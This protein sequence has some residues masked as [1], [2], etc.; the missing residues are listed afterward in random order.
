[1]PLL[2]PTGVLR[3]MGLDA[4][5]QRLLLVM[6]ALVALLLCAYTIAKV[7]RDALF[8]SEYGALAL[9]YAYIGV[10]LASLVSV[11][12]ET[13]VAR[14]LSRAHATRFTQLVAIVC[15]I[16]AAL[17]FPMARHIT[18]GLFYLWTGSQAMM[19]LPHF[20]VIALDAWDSRR[21]RRV[22]PLLSGCGLLGGVAGGAI[23]AWLTP[24]V[25]RD[26]LLWTLS[27]LLVLAFFLTRVAE[28][29]AARRRPVPQTSPTGSPWKTFLGS[30]YIQFLA[31]GLAL[32]VAVGTLVD[33]QFKYF[34][35]RLYP[36]P[37]ALTQF[38]GT[39]YVGLNTLALLFQF[40]VAGWLL[41]RM[42]L[43]ASTGL[44]PTSVL[45]FASWLTISAGPWAVV[46]MRWVQG[47]VFQTL[48][49]SSSEIY[50]SALHPRDRRNV[51]PAIDTL[52]DRWADALVGVML[53]VVLRFMRVPMQEIALVTAILAGLWL[54]V[55]IGLNRSYARAFKEA[56]SARWLET[57]V[58]P[59][60]RQ[61]PEARRAI[62]E[63]I[64]SDDERRV[65]AALDWCTETRDKSLRSVVASRLRHPSAA[66][67]AAAVRALEA[68][69]GADPENLIEGFL[70]D[71][72]QGVRR[73][74]VSYLVAR[75][76]R[77]DALV[78]RILEGDDAVLRSY[79][80]ATLQDHPDRARRYLT[81]E[82]IDRRLRADVPADRLQTALALGS[83]EGT[84]VT[85]RLRELLADP[86]L[87]VRRAA[88][89]SAA[90][91]P[92]TA[93]LDRLLPALFAPETSQEA[94]DAIVA[95][96]DPAVIAL[97][98]YLDGSR[99][100][101]EQSLAAHAIADTGRPRAR[102]LL[103]TLAR[104]S[105]SRLRHLGLTRLARMRLRTGT[106]VVSRGMAHRFFVREL[107]EFRVWNTPADELQGHPAPEIR[108]LA[109][110]CL[111]SSDRALARALYGLACWYDPIPLVGAY[112]RLQS[113]DATA[114]ALALEY[115]AHVLPRKLFQTVEEMFD[116]RETPETAEKQETL[117]GEKELTDAIR[118]AWEQGDGWLRACAVRA[119]RLAPWIDAS[120]LFVGGPED[121]I[122]RAELDALGAAA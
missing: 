9:P 92:S 57:D 118:L 22:F 100:Q 83:A 80:L 23:A 69:R 76:P 71:P 20:W 45:V 117:P 120:A 68:V 108:L 55:L 40:G 6:G 81:T 122:V 25:K 15:S 4:R 78:Q 115:L 11:W 64:Q 85:P 97:E 16:A 3:K 73:A 52:V 67:R 72:D 109:R 17:A 42:G 10:A 77:A 28:G 89:V 65:V 26:G 7:L 18:S 93:F 86:D 48:G 44:Q 102:R 58:V 35:Q 50:Y 87:E 54:V 113:R 32:S 53:I 70:D 36:D 82:W 94:H 75:S 105:D 1:M 12:V 37:H 101:R 59:E 34:I 111:E 51:K 99:G 95:L 2:T 116:D 96:G 5:D 88:L 63:A 19:L 66:V 62:A 121:P 107:R 13:K 14:R 21:A 30:R 106:E 90:R 112:E 29:M 38:L 74:A 84:A 47:V 98:P 31:V 110:S 33:F 103:F 104:S 119:S 27:G 56:L 39:F 91:R 43:A 60:T 24:F 8:L 49:K 79:V 41:Q 46:A 114:V 61:L